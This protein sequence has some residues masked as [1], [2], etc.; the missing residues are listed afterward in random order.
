VIS[1]EGRNPGECVRHVDGQRIFIG[2]LAGLAGCGDAAA[3]RLG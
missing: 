1:E 2:V 3:Q